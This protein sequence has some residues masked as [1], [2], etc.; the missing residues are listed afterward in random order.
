MQPGRAS[1][2]RPKK[3]QLKIEIAIVGSDRVSHPIAPAAGGGSVA[4]T[5]D[6]DRVIPEVD[7]PGPWC[8]CNFFPLFI[9]LFRHVARHAEYR[10]QNDPALLLGG[11]IFILIFTYFAFLKSLNKSK[12]AIV[13]NGRSMQENFNSADSFGSVSNVNVSGHV[14]PHDA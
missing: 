2:P 6:A 12:L 8:G 7:A 14:K 13:E 3:Q 4:D 11:S 5:L 10:G 9:F 1:R